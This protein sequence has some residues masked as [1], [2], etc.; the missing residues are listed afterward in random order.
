MPKNIKDLSKGNKTEEI[1]R[2][3]FKG[4]GF[5]VVRGVQV[6]YKNVNITDIDLLL[7]N[8]NSSFSKERINVDIKDKKKPKAVERI[9]WTKGIQNN[10]GL[11][12]CIVA[13]SDSRPE[14]TEFGKKQ[15]V[16]VLDGSFLS[17]LKRRDFKID[18]VSE[19]YLKEE[20]SKNE[21]NKF[22]GDWWSRYEMSKTRLISGLNFSGFNQC[23]E[24]IKLLFQD[25]ISHP[26]KSA[27]Y[28]RYLYLIISHS[29]VIIDYIIGS[30]P[31]MSQEEKLDLLN[32]GFKHGTQGKAKTDHILGIVSKLVS[33]YVTDGDK[34]IRQIK[35]DLDSTSKDIPTEVLSEFFSNT[36]NTNHLFDY[37]K[38]FEFV[39]FKKEVVHPDKLESDLKGLL[40]LYLDF[41]QISRKDF[42]GIAPKEVK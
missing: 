41:S 3:Y 26:T 33:A 16:V 31:F 12:K 9:F 13:T 10:L 35:K 23:L 5:Y 2:Y 8:K 39:G 37:A 11:D 29:L 4:L 1:L 14:V 18:R 42:F 32:E 28:L 22:L 38:R 6:N 19:E 7:Y 30:I 25:I 21:L 17:E 24:D 20:L 27:Y 40:A 15:D 34:I 36:S